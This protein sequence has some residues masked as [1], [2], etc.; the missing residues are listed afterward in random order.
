M[1]AAQA[2]VLLAPYLPV[3][4]NEDVSI[5]VAATL[6]SAAAFLWATAAVPFTDEPPLAWLLALGGAILVVALNAADVGAAA[7]PIEAMTYS[8]LGSLFALGLL[9]PALAFAMPAFVATIDVLSTTLG[10]P[11]H[12]LSQGATRL[13]DP[14]SLAF[15]DWGTKL[16][17]GRLGI[18]DAVFAGVFLLMAR[19]YDLRFGAT[20]V[21]MWLSAVVGIG[22]NLWLDAAV[23][24]LPLM[25]AAYFLVNAD[26]LQ[27]LFR[28]A[29]AG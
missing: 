27:G 7:T 24:V 5:F 29:T 25:A 12:A 16:P 6:G 17:A 19:R 21:A 11:S 20:A 18:S 3:I 28:L 2:Y 8:V 4:G 1:A 10:G 13:G 22:L 15:A 26:R 23:P 9:T 14:L